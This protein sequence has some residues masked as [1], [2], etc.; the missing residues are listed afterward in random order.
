MSS[1]PE[2]VNITESEDLKET[3]SGFN[4]AEFFSPLTET[5]IAS[6]IQQVDKHLL[7]WAGPGMV[8]EDG[9]VHTSTIPW[10]YSD[11]FN[12]T[13]KSSVTGNPLKTLTYIIKKMLDGDETDGETSIG[14]KDIPFIGSRIEVGTSK[15]KNEIAAEIISTAKENTASAMGNRDTF[16]VRVDDLPKAVGA[17]VNA[18]KIRLNPDGTLSEKVLV[19]FGDGSVDSCL[20]YLFSDDCQNIIS[21]GDA[22]KIEIPSDCYDEIKE[23]NLLEKWVEKKIHDMTIVKWGSEGQQEGLEKQLSYVDKLK[24]LLERSSVSAAEA[25][26]AVENPGKYLNTMMGR[27]TAKF[28][29]ETNVFTVLGESMTRP[30]V[31]VSEEKPLIQMTNGEAGEFVARKKSPVEIFIEAISDPSIIRTSSPIKT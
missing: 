21:D 23:K 24:P 13:D 14:L 9:P 22:V 7:E 2:K 3:P 27:D 6:E 5:P 28:F 25:A 18:D 26:L 29:T 19:R 12:E 15:P 30:F 31:K 20:K 17:E 8:C 1:F 10:F 4:S 11:A 16:T